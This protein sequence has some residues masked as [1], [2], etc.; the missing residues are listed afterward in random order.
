MI[1][2]EHLCRRFGEVTAVADVS[3]HVAQ[4]QICVLLG[5]S[6]C[7]KTTTLKMINRLVEPTSG[8]VRING[9]DTATLDSV[10]LR[11]TIGYVIQQVGLFPNMTVAENIGVVPKL[12]GWDAAKR[13]RRAAELLDI[14]ALDPGEFLQRYPRELSGGQQQRVGVAR[15]LAADPPVMLMDE[16][17]GAIDPI[18][19]DAIQDEFLRIQR[20]VNKTVLF[21]SH[22]INEAIKMADCVALFRAGRIE[23][24]GTPDELLA[25]PASEFVADFMGQDR[26]LK[27]LLLMRAADIVRTD[28]APAEPR[29]ALRVRADENLRNVLSALLAQ[30]VESAICVDAE[31]HALGVVRQTDILAKLARRS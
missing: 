29:R 17:F 23:Q 9:R 31:D 12:L 8:T 14:V 6:G 11:R 27:R 18:N 24:F 5:P 26:V 19:R 7:G 25:Q 3:L 30:G 15:A 22:D 16:P 10:A 13:Q 28:T 1:H 2:I 4:G 21:V 20:Q